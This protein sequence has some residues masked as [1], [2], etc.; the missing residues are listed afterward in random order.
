MVILNFNA[1][2]Y[3]PLPARSAP[4]GFKFKPYRPEFD[5]TPEG[6]APGV[7]RDV[8]GEFYWRGDE[9]PQ[10]PDA[11]ADLCGMIAQFIYSSAPRPNREAAIIGAD[12]I[13]AAFGAREWNISGTGLQ[14]YSILVGRTGIGKEAYQT[15]LE[16]LFFHIGQDITAGYRG[17]SRIA[18]GPA[19]RSDLGE[20][21]ENRKPLSFVLMVPEIGHMVEAMLANKASEHLKSLEGL[22][23]ELF[24]KGGRASTIGASA[25]ADKQKNSAS[26]AAP[27]VSIVGETTPEKFFGAL[28]EAAIGSG[29]LPRLHVVHTTA[30]RPPANPFAGHPPHPELIRRLKH[31]VEKADKLRLGGT[32]VDIPYQALSA[33][34]QE[35]GP[36]TSPNDH[37]AFLLNRYDKYCD[38]TIRVGHTDGDAGTAELHNRA[39]FI[40]LRMASRMA[41]TNRPDNPTLDPDEVSWCLR[42][43]EAGR[44]SLL[45]KFTSGEVGND[46]ETY[47]AAVK[48]SVVKF[49]AMTPAQRDGANAEAAYQT[50]EV[51]SA[52]YLRRALGRRQAIKSSG[53]ASAIVE[54][55]LRTAVR[56]GILVPLKYEFEEKNERG[57][58]LGNRGDVKAY[59]VGP[60]LSKK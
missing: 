16:N 23:L 12:A 48:S 19:L 41:V 60:N 42:Q 54:D 13:S 17:P 29:L 27:A 51:I 21:A 14:S 50:G 3:T 32:V 30:Q 7:Y 57:N 40:A 45:E 26:V 31:F 1:H 35:P 25:Y 59:G 37:V 15:G 8:D 5:V 9:L 22:L 18:S 36:N 43:V 47:L 10:L 39:H 20:R 28:T 52:A 49:L 4:L 56:R 46:D 53:R 34:P 58:Q 2:D 44:Q 6:F 55:A 24:G 38:R 33:A 11:P